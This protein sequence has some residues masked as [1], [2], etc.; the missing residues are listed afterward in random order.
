MIFV[1]ARDDIVEPWLTTELVYALGDFVACCVPKAREERHEFA[2]SRC[3]C[4]VSEN[5]GVE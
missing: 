3:G 5:D 1:M 2:S 4:I